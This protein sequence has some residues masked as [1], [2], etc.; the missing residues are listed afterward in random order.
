MKRI[1]SLFLILSLS[2]KQSPKTDDIGLIQKAQSIHLETITLDTHDDI[3]VENFTD[4]FNYTMD[5]DTQVNLP[6]M[7][8]GALDVAWFIVYTGQGDLSQ[9]GY[10]KAA[11][12]AQA[13]FDAI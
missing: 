5:L 2:C 3:N 11:D 6:K 10:E 1:F 8:S 4:S 12:N 7:E 13:K 9:E